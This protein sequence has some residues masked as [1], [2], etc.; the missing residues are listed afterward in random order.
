MNVMEWV[1]TPYTHFFTVPSTKGHSHNTDDAIAKTDHRSLPRTHPILS[2]LQTQMS[3]PTIPML[4]IPPTAVR[5]LCVSTISAGSKTGSKT[6][7]AIGKEIEEREKE[8]AIRNDRTDAVQIV[9]AD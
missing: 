6:P 2:P 9:E 7:A 3:P 8:R 1:Q 5:S 4:G